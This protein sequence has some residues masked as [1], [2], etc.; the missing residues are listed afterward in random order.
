MKPLITRD[1]VVEALDAVVEANPD[2]ANRPLQQVHFLEYG[3]A[4][5]IVGHV[6]AHLGFTRKDLTHDENLYAITLSIR[7]V[8]DRAAELMEAVQGA[9]D[10]GVDDHTQPLWSELTYLWR[11]SD[12]N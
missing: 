7:H 3:G 4:G 8:S 2:R 9:A 11:D 12:N 6:L 1:M 5:C 10:K